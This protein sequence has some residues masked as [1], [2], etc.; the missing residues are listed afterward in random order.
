MVFFSLIIS[1]FGAQSVPN[2]Q[3]QAPL[4]IIPEK[5]HEKKINFSK[6]NGC[7]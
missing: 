7:P 5:Q 4:P 1:N 3:V 6:V 2:L